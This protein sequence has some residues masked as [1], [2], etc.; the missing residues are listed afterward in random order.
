[1]LEDA[2]ARMGPASENIDRMTGDMK[3]AM[4]DVRSAAKRLDGV[5]AR[6]DRTLSRFEGVNE[7]SVREFLQVQG[8]RV[9]LIPDAAVTT[10]IKKLREEAVPLP[11]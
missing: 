3:T 10:R 9:N 8:V 1:M 5:L 6:F 7:Q 4:V 2:A 11:E